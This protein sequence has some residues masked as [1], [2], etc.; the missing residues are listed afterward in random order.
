MARLNPARRR[1]QRAI[2]ARHD[3]AV[4]LNP[5][6]QSET[7]SVRS[8]HKPTVANQLIPSVARAFTPKPL[9][10]DSV[11]VRGRVSG[12]QLVKPKGKARWS[13]D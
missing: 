2:L 1:A 10:W 9:N 11:G 12:G 13:K 4:V 7:G 8:S 6:T 3:L 5:T